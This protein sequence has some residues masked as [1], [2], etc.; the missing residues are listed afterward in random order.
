MAP[1]TITR[2][3]LK[4]Y[5]TSGYPKLSDFNIETA[6][7][8][9][10][11]QLKVNQVLIQPLYFS[12]DP[13]QRGRLSGVKD[14]YVESYK[15]GEP[16]TNFL[17]A[18]VLASTS[19]D[20]KEGDLVTDHDGKFETMYITDAKHV[21]KVTV[22]DGMEIRDFVGVL[23]MPSYTAYYG[24]F[25]IGKP[26]AGETILVSSASGAVGQM[27]LQLAKAQ[28]LNVIGVAGSDEKLEYVKQLGA[29]TV[30]N[31]KTC[32]NLT[33]AIRK[34]APNGVDIFYDNVGGELLD[35]AL[36]NLN[37]YARVII[38]GAISQYNIKSADE[39]Y[40]I[41]NMTNVLV[42]KAKVEGFIILDLFDSPHYPEFVE[43][44][45]KLYKEG[46]IKYKTDEIDGISNAPQ[47]ILNLF[48]GKNF[49][50]T[51]VKA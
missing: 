4:D 9:T 41:K 47:A 50:K 6:P 28:G 40:G 15:K 25:V 37:D 26:K 33:E 12:V 36:A 39:I 35:A 8:P 29:D 14:S 48:E 30:F 42:R 45:S 2:I 7:A 23:S 20:I 1:S 38:C 49:G 17:V 19:K 21:N 46:K 34:A 32:G 11:D 44:V 5:V 51:I 27:V 43:K 3:L 18:K 31:Y 13:Y 22:S 24:T 10:K 16:I